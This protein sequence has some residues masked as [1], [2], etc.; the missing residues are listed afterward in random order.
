MA[1]YLVK[2]K[3]KDEFLEEFE[4]KIR[5]KAFINLKPFGEAITESL[6]NARED[7][8]GY[9]LWEELDYCSPPLKQEKEQVLDRY[10]D[11]D[12]IIPVEEGEG[13]EKISGFPKVFYK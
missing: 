1:H 4:K 2:A 10:V 9:W 5:E 6:E 8:D 3:V 12:R 11:I 7:E 13:W